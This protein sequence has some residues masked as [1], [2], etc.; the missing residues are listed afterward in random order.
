[1]SNG[2]FGT[3]PGWLRENIHRHGSRYDPDDLIERAIGRPLEAAPYLRY[4]KDKFGEL[5]RLG[6][7]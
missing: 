2:E 4:L 7:A 6:A 3:L 1:M 5:Y